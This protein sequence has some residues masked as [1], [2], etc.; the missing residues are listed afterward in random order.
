MTPGGDSVNITGDARMC[1]AVQG[2]SEQETMHKGVDQESRQLV[3]R[4][5]EIYTK[6]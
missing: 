6:T 2:I 1:A 5:A 4:G 3:V